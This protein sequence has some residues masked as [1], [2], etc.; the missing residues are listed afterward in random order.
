[1]NMRPGDEVAVFVSRVLNVNPCTVELENDGLAARGC[2]VTDY[3]R[4]PVD[5]MVYCCT[6]G[7]AAMGHETVAE[8]IRS[9]RPGIPV[10]T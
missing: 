8:N 7:T 10:I 2:R 6:S 4:R 5:A 3:S 9:V 1:M